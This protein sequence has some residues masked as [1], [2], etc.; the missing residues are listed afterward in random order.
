MSAH[1]ADL[2]LARRCA[3]GDEHAWERFVRE[4]RPLLY[5]AADALDR[6]Q[7]AREIA[8]S[9][10]AELYGMTS[11]GGDR[12]SLFRYYQGR[13]SL[14]TWLRAVLAQRYVDRVRAQRKA[15][16]LPDEEPPAAAGPE[17][18]PHR[19]RYVALARE[20]LGR[21][22]AAL[23]PRDR[24]RLGCYY[25]QELTLAETGRIMNESEATSS[26][27]LAR[28]RQAIRRDVE[29]QLRDEARLS[30]DQIAACFASVADDPG[31]LDLKQVIYE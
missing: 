22:V 12:Q 25:L 2:E 1:A 15:E 18:D 31:P 9:L 16:P 17:P 27:Q 5:R 10:Y 7:G 6:T 11:G 29:R 19:A 28:T 8:D 24:L 3:E 23:A 20:A 26:R 4:Y 13:S 30:D 21:A 14:A